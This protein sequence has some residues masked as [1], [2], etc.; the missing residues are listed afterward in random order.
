MTK[1]LSIAVAGLGTVGAGVLK[2]LRTMPTSSPPG[3]AGRSWSAP[4]R[5]ATAAATAA[6]RS[7]RLRWYDDPVA[8]AA[9]PGTDVVV[10]LIG[11]SDGPA[12]AL[13]EA[14]LA[15]RQ[16]GGHRQQGAARGAWRGDRRAGRGARRAA[17]LRGR[18]RRRHPGDQGAARGPGGQP[19]LPRRRHPERHLQLHPDRDAGGAGANSPRC[20]PRPRR[21]ATPRPTRPSTSTASTR[22]TSWRSWRRSPSAGRSIS[23]PCMSRA[24]ARSPRSTSPWPRELGYRIKLLGIAARTPAGISA[25]RASLH[26]AGRARRSPASTAS[27]TRWWRKAISS[28]GSCWKAAAPGPGRP[29]ARWSPT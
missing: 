9:D 28:A 27:S 29:P 1:P 23:P 6:C 20:W 15:R 3:P 24:S 4:S 22:R 10:E 7:R 8:L 16:A 25:A 2:L 19:H 14:A 26:G 12:R 17:G 5:R 13:V 11:G 18:G 21:S